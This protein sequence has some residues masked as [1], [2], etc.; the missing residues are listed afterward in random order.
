MS[1]CLSGIRTG[2]FVAVLVGGSTAWQVSEL[3]ILMIWLLQNGLE[4]VEDSVLLNMSV[5]EYRVYCDNTVYC[6]FLNLF[7]FNRDSSG[8]ALCF[9]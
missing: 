2:F 9:L 7:F 4:A 5:S 1:Q 3:A 6:F 8:Y